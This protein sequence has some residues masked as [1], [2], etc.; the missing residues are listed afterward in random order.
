MSNNKDNKTFEK[1]KQFFRLN[2]G[3][4]SSL[5]ALR[6]KEDYTL[7][8][9]QGQKISPE[10]SI[11]NRI[12][13]I[14]ELAEV[15][16][17]HRLEENAV[18]SLWIEIHD[19]FNK[20][21][22]KEHRHLVFAFVKSI[23]QGQFG[24]LGMLRQHFF[25]FIKNHNNAEDISYRLELIE[26]LT[27]HGRDIV[28]LEEE[29]GPW[30]INWGASE[31]APAGFTLEW[32]EMSVNII[33]FNATYLDDDVINTVV[34][35]S[36]YVCC[37]S[38]EEKVV[39]VCLQ[40][41]D[42]IIC[43]NHLP[44]QSLPIFIATLCHTANNKN[45]CEPCWKTMRNLLGTHMGY[46]AIYLICNLLQ[47]D[48]S[49]NNVGLV[50]GGLFYINM[51]LWSN[52]RITSFKIS[53]LSV[54]PSIYN[55]L[56]CNHP[57][58]VL[59]VVLGME[60]LV[61]KFGATLQSTIWEKVL[62]I[63]KSTTEF[64]NTNGANSMVTIKDHLNET[65][66]KIE[67]LIDTNAY[68]GSL[69]E[70]YDIIEL[71]SLYRHETSVFNL[72]AYRKE[73]IVPTQYQWI[74]LL[75]MFLNHFYNKETRTSI[76]IDAVTRTMKEVYQHN[77]V[78]Y[79]YELVSIILEYFGE[80]AEDSDP[81]VRQA[82][83]QFIINV[84]NDCDSRHH[85]KLLQIL[86]KVLL[87][88]FTSNSTTPLQ[89]R[90]GVD[91]QITV[92]GLSKLFIKFLYECPNN[93]ADM[94][95]TMLITHLKNHYQKKVCLEHLHLIRLKIFELLV[96]LRADS[97]YRLGVQG[98]NEYSPYMYVDHNGFGVPS[99]PNSSTDEIKLNDDSL[100]QLKYISLAAACKAVITALKE[101]LDWRVFSYI[102]KEVPQ[103]LK[104]KA[105]VLSGNWEYGP[106]YE[107][108]LTMCSLV[109]DKTVSSTWKNTPS[110]S[111]VEFQ[112]VIY[113]ALA[114]FVSYHNCLDPSLQL[115]L[116]KC[117]QSGLVNRCIIRPVVMA[118]TTC[119]LEMR[120]IMV[121]LLPEVL[122][123]MSKLSATIQ[124]A[125]PV[126]EFLSMLSRLP[127]VFSNFVADQYMAVF[128]I[129][130]PYTS[131]FKY[132]HYTVSLAHR[133]IAIW[134]LKCRTSFRRN[135]VDFI[136]KGL[137]TNV[138]GPF[139]GRAMTRNDI[140][141]EDSSS[142]KRSSSLTEQGSR[143]RDR[144]IMGVGRSTM[145]DLKPPIDNLLLT[146]HKELTET[147]MDLLARYAFATCSALPKR[148]PTADF[149][150]EGGQSATW[151]L[152][153]KL[154]TITTS[155]CTQKPVRHGLCG[156]CYQSCRQNNDQAIISPKPDE[157]LKLSVSRSQSSEA[158]D[159]LD[160]NTSAKGVA[161]PSC[162]S[163][164]TNSPG[165]ET[166]KF[167]HIEPNEPFDMPRKDS[168]SNADRIDKKQSC[169]CWCQS[170]AE[171]C[172]R[173]PTGVM[174]WM[175]RVQNDRNF[176]DL[177]SD[178]S[179]F[180]VSTLFHPSLGLKVS[181]GEIDRIRQYL[182]DEKLILEKYIATDEA[183]KIEANDKLSSR[184]PSEPVCIPGSPSKLAPSRQNSQESCDVE[185][186][187]YDVEDFENGENRLRNPVRR[188]NS[189][190][191]MSSGWKNPFMKEMTFD[192]D[193]IDTDMEDVSKHL[194]LFS[195]PIDSK[196]MKQNY[197]KDL[198]YSSKANCEAIPEEICG[199][200]STPPSNTC[201]PKPLTLNLNID[202]T[203]IKSDVLIHGKKVT[204]E[205]P[206]LILKSTK[207]NS[208]NESDSSTKS[209]AESVDIKLNSEFPLVGNY[210]DEKS[211]SLT[212]TPSYLTKKPPLS[213][214]INYASQLL[215]KNENDAD[216]PFRGRVHTLAVMNAIKK[217]GLSASPSKFLINSRGNQLK[218][219]VRSGINPS[220]VF[221]QLYHSTHFSSVDNDA[222]PILLPQTQTAIQKAIQ[223]LDW[224]P[225]YE[226][227]K[228]GVIYVGLG[229]ANSEV[230]ILRNQHGS[231]RYTEFLKGLGTLIKLSD[232]DSSSVF[233]GGLE[234][235]GNDGK[236][237]YV[238]QDDIMQ[239]IFHIATLMP[240]TDSEAQCNNK[241]KN[242][243]NDFVTIVYNE[244]GQE[245]DIHTV[246]GQFSYGCVIVEPLEHG[247]NQIT[248]KVR[249]ELRD[250]VG[251]QEP[252]IVSDQNAAMLARQLAIHTDLAS[253]IL[254][255]LT[256]D[257]YRLPYASNWLERLRQI[258]RLHDKVK[259][260]DNGVQF[261]GGE[262]MT[263]MRGQTSLTSVGATNPG[264]RS[265]M[266]M[267][268]FTEYT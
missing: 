19:L 8:E 227:H 183:I 195:T 236:F 109:N 250:H 157:K 69:D 92:E 228:I 197:T 112:I 105:L 121:K 200:G 21:V 113:P 24:N 207:L 213:P 17:N 83:C 257:N 56:S 117:L 53:L 152:G 90:N 97:R 98:S 61:K 167:P 1:L 32:L 150:L 31:L 155:G 160:G 258:K 205:R 15:A 253:Q 103:I 74:E 12:K 75:K 88:P 55:A 165:D 267:S 28:Y 176:Q 262:P 190:P 170:W 145:N 26:C 82:V 255:S 72:M 246:K 196:K 122:L 203:E 148:H 134:F 251:H 138:L 263:S 48:V 79:E 42:T 171:I 180:D 100:V 136:K 49:Q 226:L 204:K 146:F 144:T 30:L 235:G 131:P 39:L 191:E 94:I 260:L 52:N 234:R 177:N 62:K 158:S 201:P 68:S 11:P 239:V 211:R 232:T 149:I 38:E 221:L 116:V 218:E 114:A 151:L 66:T 143:A 70:I 35:C 102:L 259:N 215:E 222:K 47:K 184:V 209:S 125:V 46:S 64:V 192:S 266:Q 106:A 163:T 93:S 153:T 254:S 214:P 22:P 159:Q 238:W 212:S 65:L 71:F 95:L 7:T 182:E 101:E 164:A 6:V 224:I 18:A 181:N 107:L 111:L 168:F 188:S 127:K 161:S 225:P 154:I 169:S 81:S 140:H 265:K 89:E 59:E 147:C 110:K 73:F 189:S 220:F 261:S 173:C 219:P 129:A 202:S 85:E 67:S 43:Y 264:S 87:R 193:G 252:K 76:R 41:L 119:I 118:L 13:A 128:A 14:K 208:F 54:L 25:N 126:L 162:L 60:S 5:G 216:P 108:A 185:D 36:F 27:D 237:T 58:V 172:V 156:K 243:G 51:A 199:T 206:T 123:N 57:I 4:P 29:I 84:C 249:E 198:R 230:D 135:F 217:P 229:Q 120:D 256:K 9:E 240:T 45:Y 44:P 34:Q 91:L 175:I 174:S 245:Y 178:S 63:L 10:A 20:N 40:L 3:A 50:R 244:S 78:L 242:I 139:E 37:Y 96:K 248:V 268:D 104:N 33:K 186:E 86:E 137:N 23:I 210:Q 247:V 166:K 187:Y 132:N 115:K 130:L 77:G 16:R 142:R 99:S 233:L 194:E 133:V 124:I 223:C 80:I 2:K 141:N 231:L 241:K 179:M